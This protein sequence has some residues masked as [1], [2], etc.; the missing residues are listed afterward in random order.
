MN[1]V[2]KDPRQQDFDF[3]ASRALEEVQAKP[4]SDSSRVAALAELLLELVTQYMSDSEMDPEREV[5]LLSRMALVR[6]QA[7]GKWATIVKRDRDGK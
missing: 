2:D 7:S 3:D 1:E 4:A 5:R 6:A